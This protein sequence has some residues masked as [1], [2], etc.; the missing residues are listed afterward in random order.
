MRSPDQMGEKE[1]REFLVYMRDERKLHPTT[2]KSHVAA[3]K[4]LYANTLSRPEVVKPWYSPR[5]PFKLPRILSGSQVDA[6]LNA[7]SSIKYRAV[8]MTTYGAGL[9][10]SETCRLQVDDIDSKKMLLHVREGKGGTERYAMLSPRLLAVLRAYW[11][12][13]RPPKPYLFPGQKPD[14]PLS[15]DSVRQVLRRVVEDCGIKKPV[16]PHLLRHSFA[17]HLLDAGTDIRVIQVLLGH[18]SITTTQ[19]YSQVSPQ[20]I[21]RT[22]SPLDLLGTDEGKALG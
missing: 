4:F 19:R 22:K 14:T 5:R 13:V 7:I 18:R 2:I 21:S 12:H 1:V 20:Y 6:L 15:T 17:T 11:R 9:R 3:L 10:I 16:T 8:L